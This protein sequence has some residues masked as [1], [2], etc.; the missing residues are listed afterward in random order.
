MNT[1]NKLYKPFSTPPQS[2]WITSTEQT[3]YP[4][5]NEDITV[6]VA[7]V[8][9]GMVGI[10]AAYLLKQE[11]L[12]VA[13]IEADRILQGTTAHT[14][15]KITSQHG[16]IYNKLKNQH[17]DEKAQQY[18]NA[19]Q[20]AIKFI[21][22]IIQERQI[23]CDFSWQPSYVFAQ[24]D[25]YVQK[26]AQEV[27]AASSLG[28]NASFLSTIPLPFP[29]K[30]AIKFENQAQFHPLKYLLSLAEEIPGDGSHV[31]EMTPAIDIQEGNENMVI[32]RDGK[33]VIA[34]DI[35][36]ASHYPFYD[37]RG[38]YFA[39]IYVHR[40]YILAAKIKESFPGG[41]YINA[42]KP[43]RSLR[44]L[45]TENGQLVMFAGDHH[46]T[47]QGPDTMNHYEN[48]KEFAEKNYVVEDIPYRWS[49]QDCMPLDNVP[50]V[51]NLTSNTPHI[52]LATAFRK[53]GMTNSTAAAIILRDLIIKGENPWTPVYDPS[54]F[55]PMASAK[56]FI[57][58]NANVAQQFVTGK[59]SLNSKDVDISVGEG[60][61]L[62]I[63]GQR[64]GAYK[65]ESNK[66][67]FVNTTCTHLGCEIQWNSAEN[68]WDCPCHGSRYTYEGDVI[69]GPT[70]RPLGKIDYHYED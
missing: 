33:K 13:I 8:G 55:T 59:L 44:S 63:K 5:L 67:H 70:T 4:S 23:D 43:T 40:S 66:L 35:I 27:E 20:E 7:I 50:Y 64:V 61:I 69:E 17:G 31:F 42:E 49:T 48:L 52:Y 47:G 60:K 32:T 21:A 36:V 6:D 18:A 37:K 2:Y 15:A 51:G 14:T 38:V 58:E 10:T 62:E 65:D 16:L 12:K 45:P 30:A 26:I 24:S 19:N 25:Q 53:W 34:K 68:S 11:G 56:N 22:N 39:R 57:V 46:K 41:M 29:I 1:Q 3:D 54:R 9:G 28:I